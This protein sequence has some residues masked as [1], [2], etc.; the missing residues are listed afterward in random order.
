MSPTSVRTSLEATTCGYETHTQRRSSRCRSRPH[1]DPVVIFFGRLQSENRGG[2]T[3]VARVKNTA[4][5]E[6]FFS[7]LWCPWFS[8]CRKPCNMGVGVFPTRR[9]SMLLVRHLSYLYVLVHILR[10]CSAVERV[11]ET[12]TS[13]SRSISRCSAGGGATAA[14]TALLENNYRVELEATIPSPLIDAHQ[15]GCTEIQLATNHRFD[16]V[17]TPCRRF[18]RPR[19]KHLTI[20]TSEEISLS[21]FPSA[22]CPCRP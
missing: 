3:A 11:D 18:Q 4:A 20:L 14:A 12:S 5:Y 10:T 17:G 13:R 9:R 1:C 16:G 19:K 15:V 22:W 2:A 7:L 6:P 8:C 21:A